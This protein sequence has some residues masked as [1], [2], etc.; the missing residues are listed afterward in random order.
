MMVICDLSLIC[1][2]AEILVVVLVLGKKWVCVCCTVILWG[3]GGLNRNLERMGR[4][5]IPGGYIT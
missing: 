5:D 1:F 4:D 3:L 2:P